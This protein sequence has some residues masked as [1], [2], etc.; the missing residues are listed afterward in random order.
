MSFPRKI[1]LPIALALAVG[2]VVGC[3]QLPTA[4]SV[5]A[6]ST[7]ATTAAGSA[8]QA[9]QSDGLIGSLIG[10]V[11]NLLVRTLHII[12]DLGGSLTNG[13]WRVDVPPG[14]VDGDGTIS[15]TI[16]SASSPACQL[17]ITP[18]TLNHF[19]APVTLTADCSSVPSGTLSTYVIYWYNPG[20]L[21]WVEV[22][23]S[24]VDLNRKVVTAP[25]QHFSKYAV[26]PSG[27]RAGW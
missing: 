11:L 16:A 25:L 6:P 15:I 12:G 7:A 3:A 22:A 27:G 10:G 14:A 18:A 2:L 24:K 20:T 19:S 13:R 1:V 5:T 21:T 17:D 26:G 9:A 23:G 8:Q 4:P